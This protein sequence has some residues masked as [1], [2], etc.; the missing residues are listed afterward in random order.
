[1]TIGRHK[2]GPLM[3]Q[4]AIYRNM[5]HLAGNVVDASSANMK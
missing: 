5:I 3:G 2:A 4:I 1:M